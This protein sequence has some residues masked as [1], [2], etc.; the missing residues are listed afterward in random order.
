[1]V[2]LWLMAKTASTMSL[3]SDDIILLVYQHWMV[4]QLHDDEQLLGLEGIYLTLP[5]AAPNNAADHF[6]WRSDGCNFLS[7]GRQRWLRLLLL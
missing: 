1:M 2:H 7:L 6:L 5:Q 4:W 3:K